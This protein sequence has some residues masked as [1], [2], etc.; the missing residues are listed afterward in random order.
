VPTLRV[1]TILQEEKGCWKIGPGKRPTFPRT[2]KII[3]RV[4]RNSSH[5]RGGTSSGSD[6]RKIREDLFQ[7]KGGGAGKL[8]KKKCGIETRRNSRW[9]ASRLLRYNRKKDYPIETSVKKTQPRLLNGG[10]GKEKGLNGSRLAA[11][12]TADRRGHSLDGY[13]QEARSSKKDAKLRRKK[14][15]KEPRSRTDRQTSPLQSAH[16]S[17]AVPT[18]V[19]SANIRQQKKIR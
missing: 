18:G 8:G 16:G 14:S 15:R 9:S 13:L 19:T 7:T 11:K 10:S 3:S 4:E 2:S 1:P 17:S 5:P 12:Q 6:R